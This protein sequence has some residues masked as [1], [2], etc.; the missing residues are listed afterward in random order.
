MKLF[1]DKKKLK[2]IYSQN[3]DSLERMAGIPDNKLVEAHGT[4]NTGH[5]VKRS[6]KQEY[7]LEWMKS[8]FCQ[9]VVHLVNYFCCCRNCARRV[10][11]G[12]CTQMFKMQQLRKTRHR[13]L[14]RNVAGQVLPLEPD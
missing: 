4:F 3:I 12:Q 14:W 5:C 10:A 2:R 6:C 9:I 13:V 7:S 11:Q 8:M 1:N